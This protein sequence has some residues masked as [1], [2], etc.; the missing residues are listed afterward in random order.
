MVCDVCLL[1]VRIMLDAHGRMPGGPPGRGRPGRGGPY[2]IEQEEVD[3][4][5]DMDDMDEEPGRPG[6]GRGPRGHGHHGDDGDVHVHLHVG[7]E[8]QLYNPGQTLHKV[9]WMPPHS[10]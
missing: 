8:G 4:E 10:K 7:G 3:I 5:D 6:R 1:Q 9:P 2:D